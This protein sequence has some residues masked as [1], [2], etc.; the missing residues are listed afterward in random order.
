MCRQPREISVA[1]GGG[2]RAGPSAAP[3]RCPAPARLDAASTDGEGQ[4]RL[5]HHRFRAD[6]SGATPLPLT[7]QDQLE[8]NLCGHVSFVA[9]STAG[10]RVSDAGDLV[11]VDS[12]LPSDTFNIVC[13]AR[14]TSRT[15]D[16]RI[17][18]TIAYF[19]ANQTP[20]AWWVGPACTP[21]DLRDRL[22]R[23]GI[24]S[25]EV[26]IG[27]AVEPRMKSLVS[28]RGLIVRRATTVEDVTAY[29]RVLASLSEPTDE[30]FVEYYRR[31]APAILA[32]RQPD[33][34]LPRLPG[35]R[36]CSGK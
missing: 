26:E 3:T 34:A 18:D 13:R 36:G 7:I 14:L 30:S 27:M 11:V 25:S 21:A 16:D 1:G 29:A 12:G 20:F 19:G 10:M 28:P 32:P 17:D 35:W 6:L 23:A 9:R 33:A 22:D 15:A 4:D 24:H 31:A 5:G 2:K 8:S